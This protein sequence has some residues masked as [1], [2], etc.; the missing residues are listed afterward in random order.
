MDVDYRS[1]ASDESEQTQM[2]KRKYSIEVRVTGL[3]KRQRKFIG[4]VHQ[5][6]K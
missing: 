1:F 5:F 6:T 2:Q 3:Q 4:G